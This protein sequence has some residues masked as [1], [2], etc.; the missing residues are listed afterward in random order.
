MASLIP[1][2]DAGLLTFV[3]DSYIM[4]FA[5]SSILDPQCHRIR[6]I[7]AFLIVCT[8][9]RVKDSWGT[10]VNEKKKIHLY[11]SFRVNTL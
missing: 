11:V 8:Y 2:R 3:T 5:L 10:P 9:L 1:V 4:S 6:D 7:V